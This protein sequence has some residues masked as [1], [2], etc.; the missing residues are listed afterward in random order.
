MI[1]HHLISET[2]HLW[3]AGFL[4]GK[5]ANSISSRLAF[6]AFSTNALSGADNALP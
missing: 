5:L 4:R 1:D 3:I 2:F 6:A